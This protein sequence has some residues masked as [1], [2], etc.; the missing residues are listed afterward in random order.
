M[1]AFHCLAK[2]QLAALGFRVKLN[3]NV[4][5]A[6]FTQIDRELKLASVVLPLDTAITAMDF[7]PMTTQLGIPSEQFNPKLGSLGDTP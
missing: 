5:R 1:G 2:L 4:M 3:G 7:T 6:E